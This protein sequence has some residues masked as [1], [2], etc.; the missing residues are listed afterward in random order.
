LLHLF[1]LFAESGLQLAVFGK[2]TV[3]NFL[4]DV[5]KTGFGLAKQLSVQADVFPLRFTFLKL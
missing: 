5:E 4:F 1:D 2:M 3:R